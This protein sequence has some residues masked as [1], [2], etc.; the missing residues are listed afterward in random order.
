VVL[1]PTG[2]E[3][4]REEKEARGPWNLTPKAFKRGKKGCL[5]VGYSGLAPVHVPEGSL[6]APESDESLHCLGINV[7]I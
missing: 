7:T 4:E 3:T 2:E 6:T 5:R 1:A